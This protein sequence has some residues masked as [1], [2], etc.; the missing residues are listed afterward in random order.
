MDNSFYLNQLYPFQDQVL[1]L[2]SP[3]E[4]GF[5]LTGGTALSRVYLN[6]RF[7]DDLDFFVNDDPFFGL[8][9]DRIIQR[10][11]HSINWNTQIIQREERFVRLNLVQV[12]INLKIEMIN[13]VPSRIG[14]PWVHPLLGRI[15]TAENI[16]ANKITAVLDRTAPKDLADIWGL[17]C[18][19]K[20]SLKE[21]IIGAQG[22]AAGVF[23][24]DLARVLCSA[25]RSDWELVRWITAPNPEQFIKQLNELGQDLIFLK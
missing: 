9:A 19:M 25:T 22:K 11:S 21:A 17:C 20:L 8:W 14:E 4:T 10:L 7:S 24:V 6:H 1:K 23:P 5:H 18:Q 16:L 3:T 12:D 13:D 15:D 2:L